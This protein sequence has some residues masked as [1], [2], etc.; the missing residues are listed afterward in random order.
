[1][2]AAV[3]DERGARLGLGCPDGAAGLLTTLPDEVVG[4]NFLP[5]IRIDSP[6]GFT[7]TVVVTD[8][9]VTGRENPIGM[10]RT[11]AS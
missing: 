11:D 8:T 9:T 4:Q 6:R 5:R 1:R 10:R 7:K 3:P 2:Q